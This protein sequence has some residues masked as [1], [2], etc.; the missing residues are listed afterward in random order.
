MP[1]S[2]TRSSLF[3]SARS[4]L[5]DVSPGVALGAKGCVDSADKVVD[6]IGPETW[7]GLGLGLESLL[8]ASVVDTLAVAV[9]V[10]T[11]SEERVRGT[12]IGVLSTP[13]PALPPAPA[14]LG[15]AAEVVVV[16][17]VSGVGGRLLR[18]FAMGVRGSSLRYG[19]V[20]E[21]KEFCWL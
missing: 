17:V 6:D 16:V 1:S 3:T 18:G 8:G 13:T 12:R 14:A 19:L 15:V 2:C 20:G 4:M 10:V 21:G 5:R 7:L 9:D 11:A